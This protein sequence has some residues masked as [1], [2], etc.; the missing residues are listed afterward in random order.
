M[1]SENHIRIIKEGFSAIQWAIDKGIEEKQTT[2]GFN[3][4]L[5]AVNI[6]EL[7]LHEKGILKVDYLL[8]HEWFKSKNKVKEK[9]DFDF[10]GK[11]K[12]LDLLFR[13]EEKRNILCY[14]KKQP[15]ELIDNTLNY[16]YEFKDLIESLGV[17]IEIS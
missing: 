2:V 12:I 10:E 16:L 3:V 13:I 8:K 4:S 14:G 6:L 7:Y 9:L 1:L 5:V 11:E 17:K 15:L